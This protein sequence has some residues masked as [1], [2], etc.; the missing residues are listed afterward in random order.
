MNY[1][2]HSGTF[3]PDGGKRPAGKGVRPF[4]GSVRSFRLSVVVWMIVLG[5]IQGR[6]HAEG[7]GAAAADPEVRVSVR[8]KG[9][10]RLDEIIALRAKVDE[11]EALL[12]QR[13][14]EN[15]HVAAE[16][17][18]L[19]QELFDAIDQLEKRNADFRRLELCVAGLSAAGSDPGARA[20][21]DRLVE[22]IGE[23]TKSG[24]ELAIL[25]LEFRD[26]ADAAR[27][28]LPAGSLEAA[29]LR[30][31]GEALY[32]ASR[33]FNTITGWRLSGQK[34]AHCRILSVDPALGIVVLPAGAVHGVFSGLVF[35]VPG[36]SPAEQPVTLRVVSARAV[37]SAAVVTG[38][39]I[40]TLSPGMEA[41]AGLQTFSNRE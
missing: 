41:V 38:G 11:L 24:R 18:L 28:L 35:R 5:M 20:R 6:L 13:A 33:K 14:S 37:T 39:D 26:E 30:L 27:K 31:K 34:A 17:D 1:D 4:P 22:A 8:L 3:A 25:A 36:K 16:R 19:R 15:A 29:R 40:R 21:E 12:R 23:I 9:A 7:P 2:T 10:E 32:A